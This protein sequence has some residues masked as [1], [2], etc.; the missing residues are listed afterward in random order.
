VLGRRR[1]PRALRAPHARI[2]RSPTRIR[3]ASK[4]AQRTPPAIAA[5]V[6]G[7]TRRSH[8][9]GGARQLPRTRARSD[10][11]GKPPDDYFT[12]MGWVLVSLQN[13]FF[14]SANSIPSRKPLMAT[15]SAGGDTDTNAAICGALLGAALGAPRSRRAG[16]CRCSPAARPV[17][18]GAPRPR[19]SAYWPDDILELAEAL[20]Q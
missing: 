13:A 14:S 6:A 19:P 9:R 8:A 1:C 7:G 5:G 10:R 15:V 4:P 18:A 11:G 17:D 20:L 2:R 3:F 12:R 16:S